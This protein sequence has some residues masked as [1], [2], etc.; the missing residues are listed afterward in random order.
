M[1]YPRIVIEIVGEGKTDTGALVGSNSPQPP[2]DGVLPI[3]I[4]RLCGEPSS[5][6][7]IR[8]RPHQLQRGDW[9]KKLQS[10]KEQASYNGSHAVAFVVDTE[11]ISPSKIMKSL[12]VSSK[13]RFYDFPA[14]VGV[15]HP[16]IEAWLL[17]DPAAIASG[18]KLASLPVVPPSEPEKLP[19]PCDEDKKPMRDRNDPKAT[20]GRCTGI[21]GIVG[22]KHTTAIARHSDVSRLEAACPKSFKPF[23]D[24]VRARLL[25]LF[26]IPEEAAD[27]TADPHD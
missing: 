26:S 17:A 9:K 22:T 1:A 10:A 12:E 18:I 23:A 13:E 16:C 24:E 27:T 8:R 11:G 5:M 3:L 21:E 6:H 4:H 19:A 20:L 25:P 14:A 2:D 7:V 15:A